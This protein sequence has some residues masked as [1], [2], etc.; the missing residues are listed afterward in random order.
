MLGRAAH[1]DQVLA[2]GSQEGLPAVI[3]LVGLGN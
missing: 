2:Q 3:L 1:D